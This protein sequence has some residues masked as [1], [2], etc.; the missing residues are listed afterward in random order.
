MAT[1]RAG[2]KKRKES[3]GIADFVPTKEKWQT[4]RQHLAIL[5]KEEEELIL[6]NADVSNIETFATH[7]KA[8]IINH[9]QAQPVA[10]NKFCN[11]FYITSDQVKIAF[12]TLEVTSPCKS[13]TH[14]CNNSSLQWNLE[15]LHLTSRDYEFEIPDVFMVFARGDHVSGTWIKDELQDGDSYMYLG[16]VGLQ[17]VSSGLVKSSKSVHRADTSTNVPPSCLTVPEVGKNYNIL[18]IL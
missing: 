12:V 14:L 8:H 18:V 1:T 2:E 15:S 17:T 3:L 7:S 9:L 13:K 5:R 11:Q 10:N 16:L 4:I 6:A